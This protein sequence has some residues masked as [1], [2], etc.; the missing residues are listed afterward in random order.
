MLV[1]IFAYIIHTLMAKST[2]QH[3]KILNSALY[4]QSRVRNA[5][6]DCSNAR[7]GALCC[8]AVIECY[9]AD[10]RNVAELESCS[11]T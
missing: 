4:L 7:T 3:I 8:R 5:E 2:I 11:D 10:R 9:I 6:M 1:I